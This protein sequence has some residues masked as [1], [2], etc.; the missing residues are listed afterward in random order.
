MKRLVLF[1]TMFVFTISAG[2]SQENEEG[3]DST[4]TASKP[5]IKFEKTTHNFGTIEL[6]GNGTYNFKFTNTGKEP[7]VLNRVHSSCGCTIPSWPREPVQS[8]DSGIVKVRYNTKI[9]G[10][11]TKS[12]TVISNAQNSPVRL[13][14]KGKVVQPEKT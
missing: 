7:L 12:I 14:I 9:R 3:D 5:F 6:N 2:L 10:S 1:I 4:A 11:F 8:G 13:I